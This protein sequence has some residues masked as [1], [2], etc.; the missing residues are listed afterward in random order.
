M[1]MITDGR[2]TKVAHVASSPAAELV[3]WFA[4]SS[5]QYRVAG[6]LQ[7]V[8]GDELDAELNAARK[9]VCVCWAF[10]RST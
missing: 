1:Q 2:S 10:V 5:E 4:K 7:L 8:G 9:Q 6:Q 3:W